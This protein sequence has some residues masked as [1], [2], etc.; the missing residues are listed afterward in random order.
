LKAGYWE[1]RLHKQ[2]CRY[3]VFRSRFQAVTIG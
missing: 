2:T 3:F 1:I